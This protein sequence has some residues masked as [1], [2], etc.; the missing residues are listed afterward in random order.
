MQL[1]AL[2]GIWRAGGARIAT[3]EGKGKLTG[4]AGLLNVH[5]SSGSTQAQLQVTQQ[6]HLPFLLA[7]IQPT[8]WVVTGFGFGKQSGGRRILQHR[9]LGADG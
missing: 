6:G 1:G 4:G 8:P 3:G 7:Q 9:L 2:D 5:H